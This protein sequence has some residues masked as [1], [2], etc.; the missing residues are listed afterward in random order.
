MIRT[1]LGTMLAA[2]AE[3]WLDDVADER[4]A[5]LPDDTLRDRYARA[6]AMAVRHP[7]Y[8]ER[9]VNLARSAEFAREMKARGIGGWA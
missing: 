3:R 6:V 9:T 5:W 7:D 4:P 8:V 2:W 1:M